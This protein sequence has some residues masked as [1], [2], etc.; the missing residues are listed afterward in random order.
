MIQIE[1][2]NWAWKKKLKLIRQTESAE[3]GVACLAMISD[4]HGF[5]IDLSALRGRYHLSQHG[6]TLADVMS[7]AQ[8]LNL[9]SRPLHAS[10]E[11]LPQLSLPCILHW[12]MNHFVVLS[13]VT[14]KSYEIYNPASGI[15]K[16]SKVELNKH[17]TGIALELAPTHN[18]EVADIRE[19]IRIRELIGKTLGFKRA[20]VK[21]FI[22]AVAL[23]VLALMPPLINQVIID[24]VLVSFDQNLLNLI[25]VALLMLAATQSLI[26]LARQWFTIF[27]SVN[28]NMQWTANIFHHLIRLP[29]DWY[30]KRELGDISAKFDSLNTVQHII[31]T[32]LI[33][34]ILDLILVIGM[35]IIMLTYSPMLTMVCIITTL[36]YGFMRFT[37]FDAFK[38]AE[39]DV[40][41]TNAKEQSHFLE[42]LHGILSIRINGGVGWREN[43]WKN[44][45]IA[46]RNSQ[47]NESKLL[48]VYNVLIEGLVA[49]SVAG[50][51]WLGSKQVID[52]TFTI[53][54]LIAFL[55]FHTRFSTSVTNLI[56]I[57][58][59]FKMLSVHTE[60]IADIVLTKKEQLNATLFVSTQQEDKSD[61]AI[62][63][64]DK[65]SFRYSDNSP[66]LFENLSFT[67]LPGEVVAITGQSGCGKT[68]LAKLILGLYQPNIGQIK[69]F[70]QDI[71]HCNLSDLRMSIGSVFQDD[72][73]FNGSILSNI[74]FFS[75]EV[76]IKWAIKCAEFANIHNEISKMPMGY[77]TLV[78]EM[79]NT[80]SGG[81]KQR[82]IF[83]RALY[84]R[85]RL[86]ILDEATS[87]LDITNERKI[88]EVIRSLNLP[89][90]QIAHRPETIAAADRCIDMSILNK[91]IN[92]IL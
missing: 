79:G 46:R 48:M 70:N 40:W 78:G 66:M 65:V 83:A 7:C 49:I 58:F 30:E 75:Q 17:Y 80:I 91:E 3:C 69:I 89:V 13:K 92:F 12:D 16:I 24:E 76:D 21:I 2:L 90:L 39:E 87:H 82:I 56:N 60:R 35:L 14:N 37:W 41:S 4:W 64:V 26:S 1:S 85:P 32:N 11:D 23:E 25:L 20:L 53:G 47:L 59:E 36:I 72:Q 84:K 9:S 10:L 18:F 38:Q 31:T 68:T 43:T 51:L 44:L 74:S 57:Y 88:I 34:A 55:S 61:I 22:F 33:Q 81:Q 8:S 73:L 19:K 29:I 5:K 86:L 28:F 27:L 71:S 42:T 62:I 54:M 6:L 67:V 52:G 77:Q 15:T 45:N 50:V 63:K